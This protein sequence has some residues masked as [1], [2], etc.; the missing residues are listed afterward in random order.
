MTIEFES[1]LT[2]NEMAAGFLAGLERRYL[3]EKFFYWF[4]LSV[5]A[6][7]D[8]CNASQPYRNYS[9]SFQLIRSHALEIAAS[10]SA[11]EIEVVSFGAGQG[12]KDVLVLEALRSSGKSVFY[13]PVDASLA[14]LEMAVLRA[15]DAGFGAR[16]L[17]ADVEDARTSHWLAKTAGTPRLYLILGNSLG[18]TDPSNFLRSLRAVLR[19]DD[20]ILLDGEIYNLESTMLGYDNPAN[21][22][23]AFAPLESLGLTE[24][25]D[26]E[27]IF[28]LE[29]ASQFA[30]M[31]W[32][33]KYFQAARALRFAVAG[34]WMKLDEGEKILMSPSWK[35]S[36]SAFDALLRQAGGLKSE[37]EFVGDDGHFVMVL[38]RRQDAQ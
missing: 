13:R 9:R 17:K 14:L 6:W 26:G 29:D 23:F 37:L 19:P 16:G 3:L 28:T 18:I 32:V 7:L 30:G 15:T 27:L 11:R 38:A 31:H 8:L 1:L 20:W 36:R 24:G 21:R 34:K 22:K 33:R 25:Q 2:E 4:P 35:Y 10:C 12:D 5:R